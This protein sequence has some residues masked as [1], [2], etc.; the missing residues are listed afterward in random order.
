MSQLNNILSRIGEFGPF[1]MRVYLLLNALT[2]FRCFQMFLLV[3]VAD[4]PQWNCPVD[5]EYLSDENEKFPCLKNGSSCENVQFSGEFTSIASEWR[6]ICDREYKR[7]LAGAVVMTG[8]LLG[9]VLFAGMADKRGRKSTIVLL[10]SVASVSCVASGLAQTYE[11]FVL[12]RFITAVMLNGGSTAV[13][14]LISETVGQ[15]AK[16]IM[17]INLFI[18]TC[19]CLY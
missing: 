19:L 11:Q 10:H 18:I 5:G 2:V 1:Q 4:K 3:F 17:F 6:L 8:C 14:V 7:S 16:G 12:L 13:F 15:S 9:A